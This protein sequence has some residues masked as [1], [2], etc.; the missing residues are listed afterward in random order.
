MSIPTQ[1]SLHGFIATDPDQHFS[2]DGV[3]RFYARVG[4]PQLR[5]SPDGSTT[6]LEPT[7]HDLVIFRKTAERAC[8]ALPH[9]R[10]LRRLGPHQRV[11]VRAA[12]LQGRARGVRRPAHRP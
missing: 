4:V 3:A 9:G 12:R 5:Q 1:M 7:F 8:E 2:E 10:H 11:P 6:E